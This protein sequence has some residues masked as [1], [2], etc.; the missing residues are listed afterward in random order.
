MLAKAGDFLY[1]KPWRQNKGNMYRRKIYLW[2]LLL[3]SI[4]NIC[5][6]N[7]IAAR[8][9]DFAPR[10]IE[11]PQNTIVQKG[12]PAT[13]NCRAEGRPEPEITWIKDGA[14]MDDLLEDSQM[15]GED[16]DQ[17]SL[18]SAV[19]IG[20][21]QQ[22]FFLRV[23]RPYVGSYQCVAHNRLGTVKSKNASLEVAFLRDDFRTEPINSVAVTGEVAILECEPPR[24]HPPPTVK[25]MKDEMMISPDD[26]IQLIPDGNLMIDGVRSEDAGFYTC[27]ASNMIGSKV[28]RTAE[29]TVRAKPTFMSALEDATVA[30]GETATLRCIVEG[31]P[32]PKI[33]WSRDDLPDLTIPDGRL[34]ILNDNSLRIRNVDLHDDGVYTCT[35]ENMWGSNSEDLTLTVSAEVSFID[36]PADQTIGVGLVARFPCKATGSPQPSLV[37]EKEGNQDMIFAGQQHGRLIVTEDGTLQIVDVTLED[38]GHYICRAI[39][40]EGVAKA[41]AYLRVID[42][43]ERPPPI[44]RH[45][46]SDQT[47]IEETLCIFTCQTSGSSQTK[48]RWSKDGRPI[49]SM[50]SEARFTVL[51][52]KNLQISDIDKVDSGVYTCIASNGSGET[53]WSAYLRVIER[54]QA[55][56]IPV[57]R[58]PDFSTLPNAPGIISVH[59]ISRTSV[60]LTWQRPATSSKSPDL[61][62]YRVEYFCHDMGPGWQTLNDTIVGERFTVQHLRPE[63]TYMFMIRALN[64]N[65][66]GPPSPVSEAIKT[67]IEE[68]LPPLP[69]AQRTQLERRLDSVNID[70]AASG[71]SGTA[72][73]VQWRTDPNLDIIEGYYLKYRPNS[74]PSEYTVEKVMGASTHI[75]TGLKPMTEYSVTIQ[76]FHYVYHGDESPAISVSTLSDDEAPVGII[77]DGSLLH[78][79]LQTC[80]ITITDVVALSSTTLKVAW[81]VERNEAYIDGYHI[82]YNQVESEQPLF[83]TV[84]GQKIKLLTNLT[85]YKEYSIMVQPFKRSEDM[86]QNLGPWSDPRKMR[87]GEDL[88]KVSP[89]QI[90]ASSNGSRTALISWR[91]P[92]SNQVPGKIAKYEIFCRGN[93]SNQHRNKTVEGGVLQ[94]KVTGLLAGK[95]YSCSVT[96]ATSAGTGPSSASFPVYIKQDVPSITEGDVAKGA[97]LKWYYVVPVFGFAA[98]FFLVCVV[99]YRRRRGQK[100]TSKSHKWSRLQQRLHRSTIILGPCSRGK[101]YFKHQQRNFQNAQL[102]SNHTGGQQAAWTDQT[103]P[104]HQTPDGQQPPPGHIH[105]GNRGCMTSRSAYDK[106]HQSCQ[107]LQPNGG[108]P[109]Y[110]L[111]EPYADP[112]DGNPQRVAPPDNYCVQEGQPRFGTLRNTTS[113]FNT[114]TNRLMEVLKMKM[115]NAWH[116]IVTHSP[117]NDVPIIW[118]T[119]A[120]CHI[121][122]TIEPYASTTLVLPPNMRGCVGHGPQCNSSSSDNSGSHSSHNTAGRRCTRAHDNAAYSGSGGSGQPGEPEHMCPDCNTMQSN[123]GMEGDER[124]SRRK[125]RSRGSNKQVN[126]PARNWTELLPPPPEQPPTD[127]D[128]PPGSPHLAHQNSRGSMK[129]SMPCGGQHNIGRPLPEQPMCGNGVMCNGEGPLPPGTIQHYGSLPRKN[130]HPLQQQQQHPVHNGMPPVEQSMVGGALPNGQRGEPIYVHNNGSLHSSAGTALSHKVFEDPRHEQLGKE[131]LEFNDDMSQSEMMSDPE[132]ETPM[133]AAQPGSGYLPALSEVSDNDHDTDAESARCTDS[134]LAAWSTN[135]SNRD[136][137]GSTSSDG[138]FYT[139]ADFASAVA[140]AAESAGM[141]VVGSTIVDPKNGKKPKTRKSRNHHGDPSAGQYQQQIP[142]Q[143]GNGHIIQNSSPANGQTPQQTQQQY[144]Q[145][146]Q[147]LHQQQ[148][149]QDSNMDGVT[150]PPYPAII[151]NTSQNPS[152]KNPQDRDGNVTDHVTDHV[153]LR[154][155]NEMGLRVTA[156]PMAFE[157]EK[158]G[159][160]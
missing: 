47:L 103:W 143:M 104:P 115:M 33:T 68:P 57:K 55:Q 18:V 16:E 155:T 19:S 42:S 119:N 23:N 159:A 15:P 12:D 78:E 100:R 113:T 8:R 11:H 10:I 122:L 65:G 34:T 91:P 136:S 40:G 46:P 72:I 99:C 17:R 120:W 13:L 142:R 43:L 123:H 111:L 7:V 53:T 94:T 9:D 88:P 3:L 22:L 117:Y 71:L 138:S 58:T 45:G 112:A 1:H 102:T 160:F 54:A 48:V 14:S 36:I 35:A 6:D 156:N 30:P 134:M 80:G 51:S 145:Q 152:G 69:Q 150:K 147:Q 31:D 135:S 114:D 32:T 70:V 37:W 140:A 106:T 60:V 126:Q 84:T 109:A 137:C 75:I 96:A 146:L 73:T 62:H 151:N 153:L 141:Q 127:L 154:D 29:L 21:L 108:N 139:D 83:E 87:T 144:I 25:W 76:P 90:E 129:S 105:P 97:G 85:P 124:G 5:F 38:A 63:S 89:R 86:E 59:N 133:L 128:S 66:I 148:Q 110:W 132:E 157:A 44:I 50:S 82:K 158:S 118:A 92:P 49:P 93:S 74:A 56:T 101:W 4:W 107:Y 130:S 27:T 121:Q 61:T 131:L 2:P 39:G 20:D 95:I 79:K 98:I 41:R 67:T 64:D 77:E 26:R 28:S 149:Q 24:G 52:S 81:K 116:T 125:H